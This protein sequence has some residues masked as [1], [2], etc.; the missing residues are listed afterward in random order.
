MCQPLLLQLRCSRR[1]AMVC[2]DSD[3]DISDNAIYLTISVIV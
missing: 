2:G 3:I 1:F